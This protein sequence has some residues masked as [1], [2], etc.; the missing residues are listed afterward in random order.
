MTP[1]LRF[2]LVIAAFVVAAAGWF[3]LAGKGRSKD[4]SA[5]GSAVPKSPRFEKPRD[6]LWTDDF[7]K[8]DLSGWKPDKEG[9]WT[10]KDGVLR[11]R[12]PD[13]KQQKSFLHAGDPDW[14]DYAV[15]LDVCMTRGVD[16]GVAVRVQG[17]DGIGIDLR[18]P[19]Y[20]DLVV[21]RGMSQLGKSSI[22]N[23]NGQWHHIRVEVQGTRYRVFVNRKQ[24]IEVE[25][26]DR[27]RGGIALAAYTGGS[28]KCTVYYDNVAV[29][30]LDGQV[31]EKQD[32]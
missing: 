22:R 27:K 16:K 7:S 18:G 25:D 13:E 28:A 11:A 2:G 4:A 1:R 20:D 14:T 5:A 12:L 21:H 19:G 9:V 26:N 6:A 31:D 32:R 24:M 23:P 29:T 10:V 17:D 15:D 30:R 8:S 3:L